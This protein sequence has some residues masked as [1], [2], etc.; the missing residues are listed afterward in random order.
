M[1]DRCE[2]C[3][4]V[5]NPDGFCAC[6]IINDYSAMEKIR[7]QRG[8]PDMK[9]I[10]VGSPSGS[11][12]CVLCGKYICEHL[13]GETPQQRE[14]RIRRDVFGTGE[15]DL[16]YFFRRHAELTKQVPQPADPIAAVVRT[17]VRKAVWEATEPA[18]RAM[19]KCLN[20]ADLLLRSPE[21]YLA[22]N[23]NAAIDAIKE[24]Q[25][26][27]TNILHG[28]DPQDKKA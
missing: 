5:P 18:D 8:L 19:R 3:G 4:Q 6:P 9:A 10:P 2:G 1:R 7:Q 28:P 14:E 12:A 16:E 24:I 15:T 20:I 21:E 27:L 25:N 13:M 17:A 22:D 11:I 23:P 26:I